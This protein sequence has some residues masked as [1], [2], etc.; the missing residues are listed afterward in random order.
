MLDRRRFLLTSAA[1]LAATQAKATPHIGKPSPAVPRPL[2]PSRKPR[3]LHLLAAADGES[4]Q[5]T[6][7]A[8]GRYIPEVLAAFSLLLRDRN[9]GAVRAMDPGLFDYLWQV[10]QRLDTSIPFHVTSGYRSPKTNA[11]L[12]RQGSAV[13]SSY[14]LEG[15]AADLWLPGRDLAKVRRAAGGLE[16]GGVG[17]YP[18]SGFIHL[19]TGPARS[20]ER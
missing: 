8:D 18:D 7:W 10:H 20:W 5:A 11:V 2:I 14:H 19:D 17:Y 6:Y 1:L 13:S 9:T 4:L 3:R 15:R 12:V 16:C